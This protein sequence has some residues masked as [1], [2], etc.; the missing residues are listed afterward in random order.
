MIYLKLENYFPILIL[1]NFCVTV[2][3]FR[4]FLATLIQLPNLSWFFWLIQN[5]FL[6]LVFISSIILSSSPNIYSNFFLII[7]SNFLGWR[8]VDN[9]IVFVTNFM[10][11]K[12]YPNIIKNLRF[13]TFWH[14][15]FP[16]SLCLAFKWTKFWFFLISYCLKPFL[17]M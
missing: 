6:V 10:I 7:F 14:F 13:N 12:K 8:R 16:F 11:T 2:R 3:T 1:I 4:V 15:F 9:K 5:L 17:K